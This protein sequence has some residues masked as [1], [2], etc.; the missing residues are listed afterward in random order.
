MYSLIGSKECQ[1]AHWK[2]HKPE[3]NEVKMTGV[4]KKNKKAMEV[5]T[6]NL[7]VA[8]GEMFERN[9]GMLNLFI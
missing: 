6:M 1:T 9:T 3:C 2:E 8:A 5:Q 4:A 7:R